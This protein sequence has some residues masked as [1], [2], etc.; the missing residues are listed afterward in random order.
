MRRNSCTPRWSSSDLIWRLTADWVTNNS[1]A[2]LVKLR[3]RAAASKPRIRSS[4]GRWRSAMSLYAFLEI[5]RN[6]QKDRLSVARIHRTISLTH[7]EGPKQMRRVR[8]HQG[9][10]KE[11]NMMVDFKE[12]NLELKRERMLSFRDVAG[13]ELYCTRGAL[14]LTQ[15]GGGPDI[16]LTPGQ[17]FTVER[18]GV[19]LISGL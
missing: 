2:A 18:D 10:E 9:H 16:V 15:E 5:M 4:E 1:S 19:T 8:M 14:W 3:C 11:I 17:C 6:M 13:L 12:A 7:L